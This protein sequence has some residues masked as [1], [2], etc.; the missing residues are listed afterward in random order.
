MNEEKNLNGEF[1]EAEEVIA[2]E[3]PAEIATEIVEEI[4]AEVAEE[5]QEPVAALPGEETPSEET[6]T[7]PEVYDDFSEEYTEQKPQKEWTPGRI[8]KISAIISTVSTLV[9]LC[10]ISLIARF[11]PMVYTSMT[12]S[13]V[14]QFDL[15][16]QVG[17]P[18]NALL[19]IEDGKIAFGYDIS[20]KVLECDYDVVGF[21]K[22]KLTG[23]AD[24][25]YMLEYY[26]M[27]GDINVTAVKDGVKFTPAFLGV[28]TFIDVPKEEV[29]SVKAVMNTPFDVNGGATDDNG[30]VSEEFEDI[31]E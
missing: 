28:D 16:E 15:T 22:I 30:A 29:E 20:G 7:R 2:E 4:P 23:D 21:N 6:E 31:T 18:A 9:V 19:V 13:G 26:G 8:I 25:A 17:Q 27:S 5:I 3:I 10:L 11:V 12:I 1:T 14:Y 24:T